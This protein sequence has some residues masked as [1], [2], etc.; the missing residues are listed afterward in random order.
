MP[1]GRTQANRSTRPGS[2][3]NRK[4]RRRASAPPSTSLHCPLH[5][6]G[7]KVLRQDRDG[8]RLNMHGALYL[9]ALNWARFI[10]LRK[11]RI[12]FPIVDFRLG[13]LR[14]G[15]LPLG[16]LCFHVMLPSVCS[17]R[18]C[19][20][21]ARSVSAVIIGLLKPLQRRGVPSRRKQYSNRIL[22][23]FTSMAV[24][25]PDPIRK[26][27]AVVGPARCEHIFADTHDRGRA[28]MRSAVA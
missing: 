26:R 23:P 2:V 22:A 8:L 15:G 12:Q 4:H 6:N 24:T 25:S 13:N 16:G 18:N 9:L 3:R 17:T 20:R 19:A 7:R 27:I 10:W 11:A 14:G 1:A 5:P 21:R 28:R